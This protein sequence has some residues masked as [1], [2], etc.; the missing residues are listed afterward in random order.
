MTFDNL[1]I[2]R[3][4]AVVVVTIDHPQVLNALNP[5]INGDLRRAQLNL[6]HDAAVRVIENSSRPIVGAMNGFAP[7]SGCLALACV[8]QRTPDVKRR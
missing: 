6:E 1:L 7:G 2:E 5:S 4:G 8:G 3:D